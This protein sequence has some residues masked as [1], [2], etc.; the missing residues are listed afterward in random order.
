MVLRPQRTSQPCPQTTRIGR[1]GS[2]TAIASSGMFKTSPCVRSTPP[3][4]E[5]KRRR[6]HRHHARMRF[7]MCAWCRYTRGRFECAHGSVLNGHTG[8]FSVPQPQPQPQR[9]TPQTPHA[10]PHTTSHNN[11][12]RN[13]TRRQRQR[14]TE[15]EDRERGRRENERRDKRREDKT[16]EKGRQDK[17]KEKRREKTRQDKRGEMEEEM[18][19]LNNV[20]NEKKPSDELAQNVLKENP[21]RTMFHHFSF[22]S[23]ESHRCFQLFT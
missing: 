12:T 21:C 23:F 15:K 17:T 13:T 16:I 22:E 8:V 19:L 10:L 11:T 9:H 1:V 18:M 7:N 20:S 2:A 4:V 5:S 14:E 3:C 6:V